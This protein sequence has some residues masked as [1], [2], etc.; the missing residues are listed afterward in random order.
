[1]CPAAFAAP[2]PGSARNVQ[3]VLRS[4]SGTGG[5]PAAPTTESATVRAGGSP[6]NRAAGRNGRT[7][8]RR[9]AAP[10]RWPPPVAGGAGAPHP[11][12][13]RRAGNGPPGPKQQLQPDLRPPRSRS[14]ATGISPPSAG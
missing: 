13:T 8:R 7:A 12:E 3:T 6:A 4:G 9:T 2:D 11:A 14:A 5:R 10:P 1:R